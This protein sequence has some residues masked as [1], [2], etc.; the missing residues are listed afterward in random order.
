MSAPS[1]RQPRPGL[2]TARTSVG[3]LAG[4]LLASVLALLAGADRAVA[5]ATLVGTVPAADEVIE[6]VP[7]LV[8]LRFDEPVE[9]V[10]DAVRV[11]GP[12]GDRVDLADVETD[13]GGATLRAPIEGATE[14]TYTVAWR[15]TSEDSHA[16]S[17]SFVFHVGSRTGAADIGDE[18]DATTEVAGGVGRWLG[19]AGTFVAVGAAALALAAGPGAHGDERVRRRVR[20]LA[21]GGAAVAALGVLLALVAMVAEGAGRGLVD[22]IDLVPDLAPDTRTGRLALARAGLC[23]AATAT[24]ALV[25]VWRRS[26]LPTL[27]LGTASL[28]TASLAGH[29]W[30]APSRGLAVTADMIHLGAVAL[31]IGGLVALLV[32]LPVSADRSRLAARF[33]AGAVAL[34]V[35]VAATGTVSGWEQ[36]RTFHGLTSTTYG[37]LLLAKVGGFL[38]LVSLGWAN[39]SR[40]VP[41]VGRTVAPLTRSLRA[42]T[43]VAGAVL[44]L[45]AALVHQPPARAT[46]PGP[47][48]TT[49]AAEPQGALGD[50]TGATDGA[51]LDVTVDPARAGSNDIHLYFLDRGGGPLAVDAVQVSATTTG[52]PA[53]KLPVTPVTAD[54]VTVAGASLPSPGTWTVAVTAVRAGTPL[55]FTFEVPIT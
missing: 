29:A 35:L 39:R 22:A 23:L 21:V 45:T 19:F 51:T 28:A 4:V 18:D 55:N 14:G 38:A 43:A 2:H 34:V 7:E 6:A 27:V 52:V 41:L 31:W 10:D 54:H 13:D 8:E 47:F 32:A 49:V 30:T 40:L 48:T 9:V 33:S 50:D 12:D 20:P 26:S 5:H 3:V 15:V 44:A 46:A 11:F 16:L 53:R 36:V 25:A 17:G 42:E 24:A 1:T 37:Q